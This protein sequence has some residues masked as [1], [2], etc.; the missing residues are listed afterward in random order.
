MPKKKPPKFCIRTRKWEGEPLLDVWI[1]RIDGVSES[2]V[3]H[4]KLCLDHLEEFLDLMQEKGF[5]VEHERRTLAPVNKKG[6]K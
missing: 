5:T 4:G 1:I 3:M 6:K 2:C